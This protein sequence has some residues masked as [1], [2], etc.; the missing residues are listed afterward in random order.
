MTKLIKFATASA[1]AVLSLHAVP[2]AAHGSGDGLDR[3]V[4]VVNASSSTIRE[5]HGTPTSYRNWGRDL[6][7]AF[8]IESG[9]QARVNFDVGSGQCHYD[10]QAKMANGNSVSRRNVNV[11]R[12]SRWTITD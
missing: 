4:V 3:R 2:A 10:L 9:E 7:P 6:I 5:I 11:C 1:L 8:V 12:V